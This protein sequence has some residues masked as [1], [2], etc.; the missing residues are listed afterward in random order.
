M[1]GMEIT[2]VNGQEPAIL[3]WLKKMGKL[4]NGEDKDTDKAPPPPAAAGSSAGT[5]APPSGTGTPSFSFATEEDKPKGSNPFSS[6]VCLAP[7]EYP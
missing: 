6:F 2:W 1:K 4:S 3:G 5:S 7:L